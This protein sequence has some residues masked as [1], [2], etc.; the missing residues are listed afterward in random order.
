MFFR[1]DKSVCQLSTN[2]PD[3]AQ[4]IRQEYF[5]IKPSPF[6][7]SIRAIKEKQRI[8]FSLSTK[9]QL[10]K[11][12]L[13]NPNLIQR[14][15]FVI[16]SLID[17]Y[18]IL[19]QDIFLLHGASFIYENQALVF[20]GE[21]GSGKT[22]LLKVLKPKNILSNDTVLV[23]KKKGDFFVLC[24]IFDKKIIKQMSYR[25]IPLSHIFFLYKGK[26]NRIE[27][28]TVPQSMTELSKNMNFL[29]MHDW[30]SIFLNQKKLSLIKG[31]TYGYLL[32]LSLK[33]KLSRL[34]FNKEIGLKN[35]HSYL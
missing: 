23:Q 22:T 26:K 2:D 34:F 8:R 3:L 29:M 20:L 5:S 13:G 7:F 9:T 1:I 12:Y 19:Y 32:D 16:Q 35:I 14:K 11:Y 31:K 18:L 24:S 6:D 27:R 15:E 25:K 30:D 4:F 28:I 17:S 10:V 33:T 21:S